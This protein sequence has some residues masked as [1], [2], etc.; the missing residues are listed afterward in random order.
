MVGPLPLLVDAQIPVAEVNSPLE[1]VEPLISIRFSDHS[2]RPAASPPSSPA[3]EA[4]GTRVIRARRSTRACQD[5]ENGDLIYFASW[6]NLGF[7]YNAEGIGQIHV[8][9]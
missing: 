8:Y 4:R 6:G 7:Y 9:R 2:V 5:P 1:R 3:A